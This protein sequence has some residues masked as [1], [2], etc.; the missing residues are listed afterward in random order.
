MEITSSSG[1]K[2]TYPGGREIQIDYNDIKSLKKIKF[3]P[4]SVDC[5]II[6]RFRG[7]L[8]RIPF[9]EVTAP[10]ESTID[11]LMDTLT[12]YN[13]RMGNSNDFVATVGQTKF[14]TTFALTGNEEYSI[15]GS[16][17]YIGFARVDK[18]NILYSGS[19][20]RGGEKIT[21]KN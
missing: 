6:R 9:A 12:R 5:I 11:D 15:D 3:G 13:L 8:I 17:Q 10:S 20:F 2:I 4:N 14:I 19:A 21:V 16:R 1:I 7:G 18:N